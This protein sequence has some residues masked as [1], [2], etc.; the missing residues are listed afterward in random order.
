MCLTEPRVN[1]KMLAFGK[2]SAAAAGAEPQNE[3]PS[4]QNRPAHHS[5]KEAI[6]EYDVV[7]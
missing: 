3:H 7:R 2:L 6:E 1:Q 4:D 5:I